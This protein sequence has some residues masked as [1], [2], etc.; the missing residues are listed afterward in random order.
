MFLHLTSQPRSLS[1][2]QD[3][4]F[5]K[6]AQLEAYSKSIKED[7]AMLDKYGDQDPAKISKSLR[8]AELA[9]EMALSHTGTFSSRVKSESSLDS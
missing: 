6:L 5:S 9:R 4:R 2:F 3:E 7:R 1:C 8:S